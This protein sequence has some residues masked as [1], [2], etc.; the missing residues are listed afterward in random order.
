MIPW[1]LINCTPPHTH[2]H[3]ALELNYVTLQEYYNIFSLYD[4]NNGSDIFTFIVK[5]YYQ[6]PSG[7]LDSSTYIIGKKVLCNHLFWI[8]PVYAFDRFSF[9]FLSYYTKFEDSIC[10]Q[11]SVGSPNTKAA[12]TSQVTSHINQNQILH[13]RF[14]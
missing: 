12:Y 13:F 8:I 11:Y 5:E 3:W 1:I 14:F 9:F 10:T 6:Q 7:H 2:T 4:S